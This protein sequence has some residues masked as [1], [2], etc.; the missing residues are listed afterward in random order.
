MELRPDLLGHVWHHGV[1]QLEDLLQGRKRR[2]SCIGVAVVEP[3]LDRFRVPVAEIVEGQPIKGSDRG[4]ELEPRDRVFEKPAS[5]VETSRDPPLFDGVWAVSRLD[6]LG[7]GEH[8]PRHVPQLVRE[9]PSLFDSAGREAH[10]LRGRHLQ[11]AVPSRVR[12]VLGDQIG[13]VDPGAEAL[14]HPPPVGREDH[15]VVVHVVKREVA[16]HLDARPDHS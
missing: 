10:V 14:R 11:E 13:R 6:S 1:K 15:R 4:R 16:H 2:G 3:G 9:L 7:L 5:A 8:Q 12:A